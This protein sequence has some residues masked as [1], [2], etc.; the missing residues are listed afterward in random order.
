MQKKKNDQVKV[1]LTG[2]HA[3]TTA[4]ATIQEILSRKNNWKVYWIGTRMAFEGRSIPTLE[5]QFSSKVGVTFHPIVS[6]RLQRKFSLWTI[7]SLVRIPVGFV[8]AGILLIKIRPKVILSFGGYSAFPVVVIGWLMRISIVLHEQ[9]SAAGLA[10]KLSS[11]FAKKIAV[12]R[13]RSLEFFPK[14]KTVVVGNPLL[15]NIAKI[16]PKKKMGSPPTIFI[17]GGSRGSSFINSLL[18]SILQR[19]LD[20]FLV[21]HQTGLVDFRKFKNLKKDLTSSRAKI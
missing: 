6:G 11:P 2:G 19:L 14:E 21:I 9:T 1:V 5:S 12:S 20:R 8:H 16:S 13:K 10:N 17:T 3:A 15:A 7:P 4:I 18:Q